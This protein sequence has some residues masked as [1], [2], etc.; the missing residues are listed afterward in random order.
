MFLGELKQETGRAPQKVDGAPSL[1]AMTG[2]PSL[3]GNRVR[4]KADM[5]VSV[6]T[7]LGKEERKLLGQEELCPVLLGG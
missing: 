5:S 7:L 4:R 2:S 1:A 3:L 6:S